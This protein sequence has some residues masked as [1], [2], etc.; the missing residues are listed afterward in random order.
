[1]DKE[2]ENVPAPTQKEVEDAARGTREGDSAAA[3][4]L[5]QQ[6]EAERQKKEKGEG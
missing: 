5:E 2:R 6:K 1:M 4:V 3:R